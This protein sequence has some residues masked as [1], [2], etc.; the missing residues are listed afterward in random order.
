MRVK[1]PIR[2][3]SS[4]DTDRS[5]AWCHQERAYA[6]AHRCLPSGLN[7]VDRTAVV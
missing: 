4:A 2:I 5:M 3:L 7:A 1:S 6:G